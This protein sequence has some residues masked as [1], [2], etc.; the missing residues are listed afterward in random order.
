MQTA[1]AFAGV[2]SGSD[3]RFG[4]DKAATAKALFELA[5]KIAAGKVVLISGKVV[6][7]VEH[8]EWPTTFVRLQFCE[9]DEVKP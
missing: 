2:I 8:E 9:R 5:E 7:T 1:Y 3:L 6:T 4:V